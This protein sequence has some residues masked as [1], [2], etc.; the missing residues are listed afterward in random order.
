M[1]ESQTKKKIINN[2]HIARNLIRAYA[3]YFGKKVV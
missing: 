3:R 1:S 2:N